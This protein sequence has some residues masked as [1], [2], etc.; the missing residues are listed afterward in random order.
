V[1]FSLAPSATT[2]YFDKTTTSISPISRL[3]KV[4]ILSIDDTQSNV[5]QIVVSTIF[6]TRANTNVVV[7]NGNAT[8]IATDRQQS[9]VKTCRVLVTT[10]SAR[11][12]I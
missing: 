5:D 9:E 12:L 7:V 8:S 1:N 6:D 3:Y 2:D 4:G 11:Y 10:M